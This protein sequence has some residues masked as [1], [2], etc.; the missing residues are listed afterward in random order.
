MSL[1]AYERAVL[2]AFIK[3]M[4]AADL[5]K[6]DFLITAGMVQRKP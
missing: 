6:I 3:Y 1:G 5:L 2:V 4:H